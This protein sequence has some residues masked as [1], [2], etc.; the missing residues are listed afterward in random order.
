MARRIFTGV[1]VRRN[2]SK[3]GVLDSRVRSFKAVAT[4]ANCTSIDEGPP[5][6]RSPYSS[7]VSGFMISP[8]TRRKARLAASVLRLKV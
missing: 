3:S 4:T 7:G 1:E 2:R 8:A 6:R 5:P